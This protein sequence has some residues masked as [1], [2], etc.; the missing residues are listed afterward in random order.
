[1]K[2][3]IDQFILNMT[4]YMRTSVLFF[5]FVIT[6]LINGWLVRFFT[7][8]NYF[9]IK[10]ILADLVI[11]LI[12]GALGYFIKPKKQF[13]YYFIFSIILTAI[14]LINS[15]YYTNYLSFTSFSL[16]ATSLQLVDV[17]DA[18]I[19]EVFEFKDLIY[20]Y[21][22]ITLFM[23]NNSLKKKKYF[24][25]VSTIEKGKV[26]ALNTLVV[27]LITLGFF[28]SMVT[29]VDLSRLGK[30]WNREFVVMQFGI[31][32]YQLNDAI[33]SIQPQISPLFGYDNAAKLFREFY[34]E[35]PKEAPT[36]DYTNIFKG[37]N[38]ILI[39]AESIQSFLINKSFND[40]PAT[41]N[42]NKLANEG[43]Y[44]SNFYSQ[45]SVGTSSDSEFTI[46][47]SLMPA[48]SGTVFVSYWDR[49]YVATPQLLKEKGYYTFTMHG[50]KAAFWNRNIMHPLLGFEKYYA[51]NEAY[52]LDEMLG[53]GLS[54]K[55]FF[56]QSVPI[57]KD[58]S[59]NYKNFIGTL[60]MLSNHTPFTDIEAISDYEVDYKYEKINEITGE[61]EIVSAPYLEGTK[62]GSYIKSVN[63]ADAA[64]GEFINGLDASGLLDNTVIVIYGDHDAKIKRS[65]FNR[66]YNYDPYT[67]NIL[68]KDDE[69]YQDI[70]FYTYELNR[71]VPFIIWTK[72]KKFKTEVTKVM[73]MY[74]VGPTLGNMF[75]FNNPYALGHDIFSINENVVVFPDGNWLTNK[76][77]YN[78]QKEEGLLLQPDEPV[79]RD[80]IDK[81]NDYATRIIDLSDAIIVHDLIRK[82]QESESVLKQAK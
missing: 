12:I 55:S 48:S 65:E 62:I 77:Y 64:I 28:M 17:A 1:M 79:S 66:Y 9:A 7:V 73:G 42:L 33:A 15:I 74:D 30:Q 45:E 71:K 81:Y 40:I 51:Y 46:N 82:T 72:N 70:N 60:I 26:R 16:L 29:G 67:D 61:K 3:A 8:K 36:N 54:D 2:K 24:D 75:G 69:N 22:P 41:P 21:G 18:V 20:I 52:E 35:K 13:R 31:Y 44:F 68:T 47:T 43:I 23:V 78:N 27:A 38:V 5:T 34:D 63:Y 10:P 19:G 56:K 53:L 80:Y 76:M 39:H 58:I 14:C 50:N 25:Y 6:S 57:I 4:T 32:V 59:E 37:K 11:I 49:Q